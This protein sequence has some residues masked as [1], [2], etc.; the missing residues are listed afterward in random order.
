MG[1][2][3]MKI[4]SFIFTLIITVVLFSQK[5]YACAGCLD[6]HPEII[7][8]DQTVTTALLK[9][10]PQLANGHTLRLA[11]L[12]C[13]KAGIFAD[14]NLN[15][16]NIDG[17]WENPYK[18]VSIEFGGEAV[19]PL[20][21]QLVNLTI[22]VMLDPMGLDPDT[23][24]TGERAPG[25]FKIQSMN[26]YQVY[27]PGIHIGKLTCPKVNNKIRCEIELNTLNIALLDMN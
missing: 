8:L 26:T 13:T 19:L 6:I 14:E 12:S 23:K 3:D 24:R 2:K 9:E 10:Q 27:V 17:A 25:S 15:S 18:E 16:C 20:H 4:I 11:E 22:E 7:I 21:S 1:G 5:T